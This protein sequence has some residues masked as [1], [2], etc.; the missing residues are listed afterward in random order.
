MFPVWSVKR[1]KEGRGGLAM[2]TKN[3]AADTEHGASKGGSW[4]AAIRK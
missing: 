1:K 3:G 2:G 4:L